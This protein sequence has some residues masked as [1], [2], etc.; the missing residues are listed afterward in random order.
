M[1]IKS[2]IEK[3]LQDLSKGQIFTYMDLMDDTSTREAVIKTLNRMAYSGKLMKLAKGKFYKPEMTIFGIL[4]PEQPQI[5]KDLLEENER[6]IG[7]LTGLSV[8]RELGLTTQVSSLIQIGRNDFRPPL[9]RGKYNISFTLQKNTITE[10]NIPLLQILDAIK[11]IKKIPDTSLE[12]LIKRILAILKGIP[13]NDLSSLIDLASKYPPSTRALLGAMLEELGKS[14][15][16]TP[17][18]KYLNPV[19]VYKLNSINKAL[20]SASK[21]NIK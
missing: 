20:S 11:Y 8:F 15:W 13:D 4:Q 3:K 21:W 19:S 10:K 1:K 9:K 16:L 6:I 12:R 5:V 17:L 2:M 18:R 14:A 7:Y